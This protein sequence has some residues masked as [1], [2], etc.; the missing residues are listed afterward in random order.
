MR[1]GTSS[2]LQHH[3][4]VGRLCRTVCG[5]F[6]LHNIKIPYMRKQNKRRRRETE[7]SERT[8]KNSESLDYPSN[9]GEHIEGLEAVWT[10][11]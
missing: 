2:N 10:V 6:V 11:S 3:G 7:K 4:L 1:R 5:T 8:E 9:S